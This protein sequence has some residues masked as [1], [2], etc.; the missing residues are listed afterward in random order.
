MESQLQPAIE[1]QTLDGRSIRFS[2]GRAAAYR[3]QADAAGRGVE[4]YS[5]AVGINTTP[6]K[7]VLYHPSLPTQPWS[8]SSVHLL[9]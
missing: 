7:G 4:K 9:S 2:P 5:A 3:L 8:T 1:N 6:L